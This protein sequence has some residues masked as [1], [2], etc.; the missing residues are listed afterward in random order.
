MSASLSLPATISR[1]PFSVVFMILWIV[2]QPHRLPNKDQ[3]KYRQSGSD[4]GSP[5]FELAAQDPEEQSEHAEC[6]ANQHERVEHKDA[7][8]DSEGAFLCA[9]ENIRT[10]SAAIIALLHFRVRNQIG[11]LLVHINLLRRDRAFRL[12]ERARVKGSLSIKHLID[13]LEIMIELVGRRRF[14]AGQNREHF[15]Q[16]VESLP[17]GGILSMLPDYGID[18]AL[19]ALLPRRERIQLR[20]GHNHFL[21]RPAHRNEL[22]HER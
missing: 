1:V 21:V 6:R 14:E 18:L 16:L 3:S 5:D 17:F 2:G 8:F 12:S 13:L 19:S 20:L 9:E 7:D 15:L 4:L 11:N 22:A 10:A